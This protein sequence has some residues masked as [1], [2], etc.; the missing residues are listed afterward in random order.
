M[1]RKK[2]QKGGRRA[3][4]DDRHGSGAPRPVSLNERRKPE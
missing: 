1:E 4:R 3:H 2:A